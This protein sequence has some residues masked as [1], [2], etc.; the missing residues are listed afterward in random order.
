MGLEQEIILS[1]AEVR[2]LR[3]TVQNKVPE[4][5]VEEINVYRGIEEPTLTFYIS[6]V[7]PAK[8]THATQHSA[9]Q[10][11]TWGE[12]LINKGSVHDKKP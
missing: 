1:E 7:E 2:K 12:R 11:I 5:L 8:Q 9:N 6:T 3:R 10:S 4:K